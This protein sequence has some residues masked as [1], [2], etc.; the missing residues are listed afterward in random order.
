MQYHKNKTSLTIG[1]GWNSYDGKHYGEI[2]WAK[3]QA[4]VP[5]NYRWYN[6]TAHKK[7]YS[8]YSKWTQQLTGALQSYIDLQLRNVDYT[9]YGFKNNPS[10]LVQKN[11]T[12]FNPKAGITYNKNN[13][14]LYASYALAQHEPNRDDFEAGQTQQP[15]PELLHD[16]EAGIEKEKNKYSFGINLYYMKYKDQ[17]ILTGKIND[18]GAYTRI[19]IPNSYR[20][21]IEMQGKYIFCKY[22]NVSANATF[23][24]NKIKNFTEYLD[25]YDNGGQKSNFYAST[26]IAFSPNTI[27]GG[28]INI[29]P[30]KNAAISFISKY[31]GRQY[32]DNT[33]KKSRS[34]NPYY[35]ED[36]MLSY[37]LEG[38]VLKATNIILQL[39][40]IFSK[41]YEPNGYSFSYIYGGR[42]TTENYY[43]PMATF[44]AM[45]GLSIRL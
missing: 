7:D 40:N 10:L 34:L 4:A 30:V 36:I 37:L 9:I 1:G 38:K 27:A 19:N 3:V 8:V 42:L 23:S 2:T 21:G 24:S 5:S 17:L 14:Q 45:V 32:L 35:T 25:D 41:K 31:V 28:S 29:T 33:G 12:F 18:V 26:D 13:W 22:L 15:K 39:N 43:F 6:L 44:N 16:V 11:Y 20:A